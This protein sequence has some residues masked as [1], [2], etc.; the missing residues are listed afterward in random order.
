MMA[1]FYGLCVVSS[2]LS[3]ERDRS[4]FNMTELLP[5][6]DV[7]PDVYFLVITALIACS[8]VKVRHQQEFFDQRFVESVIGLCFFM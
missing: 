3:T 1:Y 2:R 4:V 6:L 5:R 8:S 7:I